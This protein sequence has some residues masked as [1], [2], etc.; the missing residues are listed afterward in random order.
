MDKWTKFSESYPNG[1]YYVGRREPDG[2]WLTYPETFTAYLMG[3][4]YQ[5]SQW[6]HWHPA[7][8]LPEGPK[9]EGLE[10]DHAA[11][12]AE[13]TSSDSKADVWHAALAWERAEVAKI[14]DREPTTSVKYDPYGMIDA[15]R[16]R[17]G[18][19]K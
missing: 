15:I 4:D 17:V 11:F 2:R 13:I 10:K 8:E 1:R 19:G 16:A 7:P 5:N 12:I 6:T 14:L 18:G 9:E 3:G